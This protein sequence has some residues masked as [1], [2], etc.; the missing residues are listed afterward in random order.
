MVESWA[1]ICGKHARFTGD[2]RAIQDYARSFHLG[3]RTPAVAH[4]IAENTQKEFVVVVIE[5]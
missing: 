5:P 3:P 2:D 1:D 4:L